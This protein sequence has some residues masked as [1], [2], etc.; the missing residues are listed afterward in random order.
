MKTRKRTAAALLALLLAATT[1]ACSGDKS[2]AAKDDGLTVPIGA[3]IYELYSAYGSATSAVPDSSKPV[4][5]QKIDGKDAET[6]I[7]GKALDDMKSIFVI[8]RK[9]KELGLSLTADETKSIQSTADSGW[10]QAQ[11][12]LEKYGIAKSS[13]Q[14]AYADYYTKYGKVFDA[15]YGKG[16]SK[17]V[18]D[19]DLK[20]YFEKNYTD[21]SYLILPLYKTDSSGNTTDL[22]DA[23]KKKAEKEFDDYAAKI[24]SG[25]M[26]MRQAADAYKASSKATDDP[27]QSGTVALGTDTSYPDSMKKL[28]EPLKNGEV[29]TGELTGYYTYILVQ[30]NDV[31][32]KTDDQLKNNRKGILSEMKGKEFSDGIDKEAGSLT[33]LTLN[34]K[35]L[36]SYNPS[37]FAD[38]FNTS[39]AA[40]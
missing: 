12:T 30:K 38:E 36:N 4:L 29:K 33:G 18:S 8:D 20:S 15:V 21:F 5:G 2:W 14:I 28:I 32:K 31:T 1:A 35:A 40:G 25:E 13:F 39:S 19:A 6:W 27:L 24:K 11:S 34:D 3:Y 17:E 26:T 22:S 9:M 23:D 37:M 10:Q 7:R 16:G